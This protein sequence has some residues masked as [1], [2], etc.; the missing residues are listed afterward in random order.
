MY[1]DK[2][3]VP[4]VLSFFKMTFQLQYLFRVAEENVKDF[5][6]PPGGFLK[7]PSGQVYLN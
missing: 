1:A 5:T 3:N 4:L 2:N 6:K 7:C